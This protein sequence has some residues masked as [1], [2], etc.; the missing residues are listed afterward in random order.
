MVPATLALILAATP[1]LPEAN[2]P[3]ASRESRV[4]TTVRFENETSREVSLFW[5]DFR[6][7]RKDYGVLAPHTART[8]KTWL[9]HPWIATDPEGR[10]LGTFMPAKGS[11]TA[12]IYARLNARDAD[13]GVRSMEADE[14]AAIH[15]VNRTQRLVRLFWVDLS[16]KRELRARVE[17][18]QAFRVR[19]FAGHA[20]VATDDSDRE[21]ALFVAEA[22]ETTAVVEPPRAIR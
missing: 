4:P 8:V 6:G 9:T 18:G 2:V 7:E 11:G 12:K 1:L 3:S 21:L 16:G 19:T 14:P 17:P 10:V 22:G 13:A 5:L 20:W 15:F